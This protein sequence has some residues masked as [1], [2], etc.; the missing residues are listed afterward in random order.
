MD[1]LQM[2]FPQAAAAPVQIPTLPPALPPAT[3]TP[4]VAAELEMLMKNPRPNVAI[5]KKYATKY[6]NL[7]KLASD[8]IGVGDNGE[9]VIRG[10]EVANSS[11]SDVM[12][13]LYSD[14]KGKAAALPGLSETV[15]ELKRLNVPSSMITSSRARAIYQS[16]GQKGSGK[17]YYYGRPKMLRLY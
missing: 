8:S 6:E 16:V 7:I 3:R 15:G 4:A 14:T 13:A 11:Y 12:R 17:C 5:P 1:M 2:Q 10:R 9:V